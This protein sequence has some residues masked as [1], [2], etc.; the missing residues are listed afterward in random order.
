MINGSVAMEHERNLETQGEDRLVGL[1]NRPVSRLLILAGLWTFLGL[2]FSSARY[3]DDLSLGR[4]TSIPDALAFGLVNWYSFALLALPVLR[5]ARRFPI[6]KRTFWSRIPLYAVGSLLFSSL[7][8]VLT[9]VLWFERAGF[10]FLFKEAF[11]YHLVSHYH[12]N[13]LIFVAI[14]GFDRVARDYR[15]ARERMLERARLETLLAESR[16]ETLRAQLQPHFLFNSL[17]AV[18][19]L[20][21]E[22]RHKAHDLL[23]A[24]ADLL[25]LTLEGSR[26]Q[27]VTLEQETHFIRRYAAVQRTRFANRLKVAVEVEEEARDALVPSLILQPLVENAIVHGIAPFDKEGWVRVTGSLNDGVL[28]LRVADSGPGIPSEEGP[29]F[30]VGLSTCRERLRL[31]YGEEHRMELTNAS[32]GGLVVEIEIPYRTLQREGGDA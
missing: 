30:G 17:N 9:H 32:Q 31:L 10:P 5:I 16:L 7:H 13:V 18:S 24:I 20:I 15:I 12:F 11:K 2:I 8:T 26:R 23:T 28:R 4:D 25:R 22:S 19:S 1:F 14:I 6:D 27:E 29:S 3:V 21:Y